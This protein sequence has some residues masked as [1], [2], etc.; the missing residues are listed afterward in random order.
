MSSAFLGDVYRYILGTKVPAY[1][2]EI[3]NS[4]R[5]CY[6]YELEEYCVHALD[7]SW[8][9][10]SQHL[11]YRMFASFLDYSC[12][13]AWFGII[14]MKP[15]TAVLICDQKRSNLVWGRADDY[16]SLS[17]VSSFPYYHPP[18]PTTGGADQP[19]RS[20]LFKTARGP[21]GEGCFR[22]PRDSCSAS[23]EVQR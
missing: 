10:V 7:T 9:H 6:S 5:N 20:W 2:C 18:S 16:T 23:G 19:C 1:M 4:K 13:Y 3:C 11:V 17:L 8:V 14:Y 21:T 12:M 22:E 15:S